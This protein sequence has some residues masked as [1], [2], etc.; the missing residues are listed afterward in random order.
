MTAA[1][2]PILID[3]NRI[4]DQET[5]IE[6]I[7]LQSDY[8]LKKNLEAKEK[9]KNRAF[10]QRE[11]PDD[12][13]QKKVILAKYD[14]EQKKDGITLN[15]DGEYDASRVAALNNIKSKLSSSNK[16]VISLDTPRV[17]QSEYLTTEEDIKESTKFKKT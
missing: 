13:A 11:D 1:D 10:Y 12:Y 3:G 5:S 2:V 14:E 8:R 6:N 9:A 4:N 17:L 16:N 7:E 15:A